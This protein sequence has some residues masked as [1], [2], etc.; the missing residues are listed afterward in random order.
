MKFTTNQFRNSDFLKKRSEAY[1]Q[2]KEQDDA[3]QRGFLFKEKLPNY[4]AKDGENVIRIIP[5]S[6]KEPKLP[7]L[8]CYAHYQVG[9][10]NATFWCPSRCRKEPC[11]ICDEAKAAKDRG[12]NPDSIKS[13]Y[14]RRK[15][16]MWLIDRANA[17]TGPQVWVAPYPKVVDPIFKGSRNRSTGAF[18]FVD[19]V[20]EG[21]DVAFEVKTVNISPTSKV[22]QYEA[23]RID[24]DSS[25]L[26]TDPATM[27]AWMEFVMSK[28]TL[29]E[30]M[31]FYPY[32]H[33]K[34]TLTG[35][36]ESES[37][38][39]DSQEE[40]HS[41]SPVNETKSSDSLTVSK[42]NS[43]NHAQIC[44]YI[45]NHNLD[46]DASLFSNVDHL[47]GAVALE[48]GIQN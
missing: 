35:G 15:G 46:V 31:I 47:R 30:M 16:A 39:E 41:S 26:S 4:K 2:K 7:W 20:K 40:S 10:D 8:E 33:I 24:R 12:D 19:D 21:F 42:L 5:W 23:P 44:E 29:E 9:P 48:L 37:E 38:E 36:V 34:A 43:M 11:P 28:P 27:E 6:W 14:P 45:N 22:P 32:D 18:I 25:P 1:A 3:A 13:L 17:G